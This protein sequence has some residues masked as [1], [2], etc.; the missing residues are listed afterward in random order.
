MFNQNVQKW[1]KTM[2]PREITAFIVYC[3]GHGLN[4]SE[5]VRA[6]REE[7]NVTLSERTVY[8]KR[9]SLTA[10]EMID[11]LEREQLRDI[12]KCDDPK[13]KMQMRNELLKILLPIRMEILSK[14]LSINKVEVYDKSSELA[15][16]E[17]LLREAAEEHIR[18]VEQQIR[19][20]NPEKPLHKTDADAEASQV[21]LTEQV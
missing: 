13:L 10:Q 14:T 17:Q 6:L 1:Q 2:Y 16:Y 12:A 19:Q 9:Q 15:E 8:R 3:W 21:S 20:G 11:E 18:Q 4:A 5:T 7:K